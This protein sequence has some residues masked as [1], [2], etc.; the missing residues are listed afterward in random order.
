MLSHLGIMLRIPGFS[1]WPSILYLG[2]ILGLC[3]V[4]L[5]RLGPMLACL[6]LCWEFLGAI[7]GHVGPVLAYLAASYALRQLDS[8]N[9]PPKKI[10]L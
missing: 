3:W 8:F 5:G 2:A 1:V 7:L 4:L 6:E 9:P 10:Y